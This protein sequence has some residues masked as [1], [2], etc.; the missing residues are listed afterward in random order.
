MICQ[1][2]NHD[3]PIAR[4]MLPNNIFIYIKVHNHD[5]PKRTHDLSQEQANMF[6]EH[7]LTFVVN[8][9]GSL[10]EH[11]E[12]MPPQEH[13]KSSP[14]TSQEHTKSTPRA[15]NS[16]TRAPKSTARA[17]KSI[18][19]ASQEHPKSTQDHPKTVPRQPQEQPSSPL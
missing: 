3:F 17:P 11:V 14:R 4:T 6:F 7:R 5:F 12:T 16:T 15:P 2:G 10:L 9:L 1:K 13:S 18:P 8:I 19:R